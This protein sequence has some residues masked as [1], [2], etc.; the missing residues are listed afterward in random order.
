MYELIADW[1]QFNQHHFILLEFLN[2]E[3]L[4]WY[5]LYYQNWLSSPSFFLIL[6][7]PFYDVSYLLF[8]H[9]IVR[10]YSSSYMAKRLR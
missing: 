3:Y 8:S 7:N 2:H 1:K 6:S 9:I 10:E 4:I 5:S